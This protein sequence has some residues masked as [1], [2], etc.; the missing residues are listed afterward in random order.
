MLR[1]RK[2]LPLGFNK[3]IAKHSSII[4]IKY[5]EHSILAIK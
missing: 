3:I 1:P 5:E 4:S 2:P